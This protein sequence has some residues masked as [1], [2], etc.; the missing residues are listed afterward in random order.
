[1]PRKPNTSP[2]NHDRWL[3]SYADFITLLFAFF[4]VMFASTQSDKIK[5]KAVS[6]SVKDALEHGQLSSALATALGRGK[7]EN[8]KPPAN[9]ERV[10]Q[11][12][13]LKPG[14]NASSFTQIS[15]AP[16]GTIFCSRT[17][18]VAPINS[19]TLSTTRI[20]H[21]IPLNPVCRSLCHE[22]S[23]YGFRQLPV[24]PTSESCKRLEAVLRAFRFLP[25]LLCAP[26]CLYLLTEAL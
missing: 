7:H 16:S 20:E 6:E 24:N 17:I 13:M 23:G 11:S 8:S 26:G 10:K 2:E 19:K 22:H 4:V 21:F 14:L 1:M 12:L 15:A 25:A 3:V 9:P 18:G 5:A